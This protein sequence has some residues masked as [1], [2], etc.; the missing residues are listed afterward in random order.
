[1]PSFPPEPLEVGFLKR[2]VTGS[3]GKEAPIITSDNPNMS[4]YSSH[5]EHNTTESNHIYYI[6]F[7]NFLPF[8][9]SCFSHI[10]TVARNETT[11]ERT[12]RAS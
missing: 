7:T 12:S 3:R 10:Q 5:T 8:L 1:M 2:K 6:F 4:A 11:S 9:G